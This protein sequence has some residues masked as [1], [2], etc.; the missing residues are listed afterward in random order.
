MS[1]Q[2]LK[3]AAAIMLI[4]SLIL[5]A[6]AYRLSKPPQ[7][8]APSNGKIPVQLTEKNYSLVTAARSIQPGEII[9]ESDVVLSSFAD[10]PIDA[11]E[12]PAE[13]LGKRSATSIAQGKPMLRS[14]FAIGN[15]IAQALKANERAIAIKVNEVIGVGG[16]IQPGDS[17]DVIAFIHKDNQMVQENQAVVVLHAVRVLSYGDELQAAIAD[18]AVSK[19]EPVKSKTGINTAVIAVDA[20]ETALIALVE[21]LGVLRLAL[22]PAGP[23]E[24]EIVSSPATLNDVAAPQM[25]EPVAPEQPQKPLIEIYHGTQVEQVQYP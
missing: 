25:V 6:I 16:F 2:I 21:N 19:T 9:L 12:A 24:N 4:C 18:K 22:R 10:K 1:S 13:V 20:D 14:H 5:I 23:A 15:P 7:P 11:F 8:I 3:V 17:V